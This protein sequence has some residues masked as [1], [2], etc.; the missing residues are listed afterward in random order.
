MARNHSAARYAEA[1]ASLI[2]KDADLEAAAGALKGLAA[3]AV[4]DHEAR[5]FWQSLRAG[6]DAKQKLAA[7]ILEMLEAPPVVRSFVGVLVANSRMGHLPEIADALEGVVAE[8][9][10]RTV[11][12][13]TSARPLTEAQA[14]ALRGRLASFSGKEVHLEKRVDENLI[15]GVRVR[16]ENTVF[17]DS[18]RGRLDALVARFDK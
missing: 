9:L 16:L 7:R 6:R 2:E 14:K 4:P 17:D 1:L 18:V 5:L 12:R 13:V 15:G 10:G 11:A 8:R 3:Q